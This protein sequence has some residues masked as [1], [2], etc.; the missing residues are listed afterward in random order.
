MS[1][2]TS[3]RSQGTQISS[4]HPARRFDTD[5]VGTPSAGTASWWLEDAKTLGQMNASRLGYDGYL[6]VLRVWP[7]QMLRH[8]K[9]LC[10]C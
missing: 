8:P 9:I 4:L 2:T 1:V 6:K 5:G 3:D 7:P 10:A